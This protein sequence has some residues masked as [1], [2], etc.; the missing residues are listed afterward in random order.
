MKLTIQRGFTLIEL[1][2]VIAILGVLAGAILVAL[3]PTT[4]INSAKATTAKSDIAQIVNALQMYY[5]GKALTGEA[6]AYPLTGDATTGGL[7]DLIPDELKSL[8]QQQSGGGGCQANP[9][10]VTRGTTYCYVVDATGISAAVWGT[11]FSATGYWCWD[12]TNGAYRISTSAN[13]PTQAL[14]TCR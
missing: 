9:N 11:L 14:P 4:K 5:T 7:A 12:S 6:M 2:I 10:G 13:R 1:L 8:P 3:S